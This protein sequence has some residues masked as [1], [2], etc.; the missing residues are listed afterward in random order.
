MSN[1]LINFYEILP[2]HLK[3][4]KVVQ[5]G[6]SGINLPCRI[7]I[8]GSSNQGKTLAI[9]NYLKL[10]QNGKRG[11]YDKITVITKKMEPLYEYLKFK[12]PKNVDIIEMANEDSILP[13]ME[14]F[15]GKLQNFVIFDDLINEKHLMNHIKDFF[16]RCRKK[17]PYPLNICFLTQDFRQTD[18]MIRK[19]ISH[20]WIFKPTTER[21][22]VVMYQDLPILK[23]T[24]IWEKLAKKDKPDDPNN[25]INID[26]NHSTM[27]INFEKTYIK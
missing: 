19:N 13:T 10:C 23:N 5:I 7:L 20:F 14:A 15:D 12:S 3:P 4:K 24:E 26:V 2:E 9:L 11:Q 25:F 1:K 27:R 22:K 18:P 16:I 8:S 21:E 17:Q 6:T